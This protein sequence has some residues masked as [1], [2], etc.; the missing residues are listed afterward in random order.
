MVLYRSIILV[1][2]IMQAKKLPTKQFLYTSEK[3][4]SL[5]GMKE[6]LQ[7]LDTQGHYYFSDN[8][9]FVKGTLQGQVLAQCARCLKE[10]TYPFH[11]KYDAVFK[12]IPDEE[13]GEYLLA[14]NT[15]DLSKVLSDEIS[16]HMPLQ[17]FCSETCKGLCPTCGANLND[18]ACTCMHAQE[19]HPVNPF[20]KLKDL[21][22]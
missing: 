10:V 9:V 18:G 13:S 22:E 11:I 14:D 3:I 12:E 4:I 16:L 20:A 2:D 8:A 7:K 6:K 15:I 5:V 17:L 19:E 1:I 21:F